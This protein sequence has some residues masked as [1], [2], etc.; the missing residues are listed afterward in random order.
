[1]CNCRSRYFDEANPYFAVFIHEQTGQPLVLQELD[2][3]IN[4]QFNP[5][6]VMLA[7]TIVA[8]FLIVTKNIKSVL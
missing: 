8:R 1:M 5:N 2:D 7:R 6:I 4:Y 3:L